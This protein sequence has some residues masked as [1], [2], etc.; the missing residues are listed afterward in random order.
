MDDRKRE[1]ERERERL[2]KN[3]IGEQCKGSGEIYK[4]VG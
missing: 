1:R 2:R 3:K 4:Q